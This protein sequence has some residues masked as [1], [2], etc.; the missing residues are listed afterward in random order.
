MTET[1][2]NEN[3]KDKKKATKW[4]LMQPS[5]KEILEAKK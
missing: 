2:A 3:T 5:Q 1:G 4:A